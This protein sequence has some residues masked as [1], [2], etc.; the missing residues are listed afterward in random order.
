MFINTHL[1]VRLASIV[2]SVALATVAI[3]SVC[4]ALAASVATDIHRCCKTSGS[5]A[6]DSDDKNCRVKC[7]ST[8][9]SAVRPAELNVGASSPDQVLAVLTEVEISKLD[10]TA[11]I[12]PAL[13][14]AGPPLPIFQRNAVLLI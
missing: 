8:S 7:A 5:K 3:L 12:A 13:S 14:A 10:V 11:Y 9:P 6:P 2:V 4:P 1:P